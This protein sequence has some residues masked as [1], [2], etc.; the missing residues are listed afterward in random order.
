MRDRN[1]G[2]ED[3]EVVNEVEDIDPL[4]KQNYIKYK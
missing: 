3:G 2:G 1:G 4:Y